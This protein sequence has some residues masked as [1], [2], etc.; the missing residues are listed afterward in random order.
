MAKDKSDPTIQQ[1]RATTPREPVYR[2]GFDY[3]HNPAW[4]I[5]RIMAEF[6]SG[7][8]FIS[9]FENIVTVFG[10]SRQK[11]KQPHYEEAVKLGKRLAEEGYT[12]VTGGGPG[13]MQGANEGATRGGGI[14]I[15]LNISLPSE[16]KL[17]PYVGK[18]MN[19]HHFYARKVMLAYA[20]QA[21]VFFPGGFGTLDE[22]FEMA[23]L[24]QTGKMEGQIPILLYGKDY[25]AG[26]LKWLDSV[27]EANYHAISPQDRKIFT[28]VDTVE[29]VVKIIKRSPKREPL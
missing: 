9:Q 12:V 15:G 29:E 1:L 18:S 17:N 2:Q 26:L 25:W 27:V 14:S 28:V 23:T 19:F 11:E 8:E 20:S 5:F 13:I 10:S 7:F 21:Y 3:Q 22:F 4:R 16:Q 6:V 24:V